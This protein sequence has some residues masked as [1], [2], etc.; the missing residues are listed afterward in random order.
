MKNKKYALIATKVSDKLIDSLEEKDYHIDYFDYDLPISWEKYTGIIT[1]NK[2]YL[3]K[4]ILEKCKNLKWIGRLGSGMEII[5]LDYAKS[6]NIKVVGSP[7]GN[8][9]AVAEQALGM[10]LSM[11]HQIHNSYKETSKNIWRRE[12]NRGWEIHGK[13]AAIIGLGNNGSLFAQKLNAMG[14]EVF[15]YDPYILN[16]RSVDYA[17]R[18]N[19]IPTLLEEEIDVLSFHV[20]LNKETENY[21][22]E[23]MLVDLKKPIYLLNLS[24][25]SVVFWDKVYQGLKEGK[26]IKAALDVLEVEPLD[27][28]P[29][30]AK[31]EIAE[32][33]QKDKLLL[34]PHIGG[35][36]FEAIDKMS[37][38]VLKQLYNT[39]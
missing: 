31:K 36:T 2:L 30:Q 15:Y 8:A 26:I 29:E 21:F 35:Y 4:E 3:P 9:N 34:T 20:P 18:K 33:I 25:G 28:M 7:D 10:L 5:D 22:D 38:S 23:N 6:Q 39:L 27:K 14:M 12:A 1:S 11:T 17:K 24:R 19:S 32:M 37:H 13:K 16:P